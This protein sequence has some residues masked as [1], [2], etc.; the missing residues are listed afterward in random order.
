VLSSPSYVIGRKTSREA[1]GCS[2]SCEAIGTAPG[3][4][5]CPGQAEPEQVDGNSEGEGNGTR[6]ARL[7]S[8]GIGRKELWKVLRN[9]AARQKG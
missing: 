1:L 5:R 4:E 3:I 2:D 7:I 6:G 8:K 9:Q